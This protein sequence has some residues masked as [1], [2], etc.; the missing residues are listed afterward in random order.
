MSTLDQVIPQYRIRYWEGGR[1][2]TM[3]VGASNYDSL[4]EALK[5]K[6]N[7]FKME[8]IEG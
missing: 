7:K 4:R 3:V 8:R 2:Y 1:E 6:Y 5:Q